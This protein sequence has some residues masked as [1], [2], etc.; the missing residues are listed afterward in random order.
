LLTNE[1]YE[2]NTRIRQAGGRVWLDPQIRSVYF[3]RGNL[4]EL[5]QQYWRYGFWKAQMLKRYPKTLRLRQA[6]PPLFVFSLVLLPLLGL[7]L[8]NP[9]HFIFY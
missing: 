5:A 8:L 7:S 9:F 3:A 6:L 2:F 1:D 4:A